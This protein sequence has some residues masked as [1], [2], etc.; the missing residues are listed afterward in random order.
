MNGEKARVGIVGVG[1]MGLAMVRHLIKH[2]HQVIAC[3]IDD[4]QLAV[5]PMP[6]LR[7]RWRT[8]PIS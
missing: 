5:L 7:P 6:R 1:R 4:K 8:R 2:G 3:D